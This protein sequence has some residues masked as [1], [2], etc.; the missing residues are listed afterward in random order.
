LI[1]AKSSYLNAKIQQGDD[2]PMT[3]FDK[4]RHLLDLFG[5]PTMD[6]MVST[7]AFAA[8]CGCVFRGEAKR[9]NCF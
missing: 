4:L 2:S 7:Q 1:V 8:G 6:R 5:F 3:A 9:G